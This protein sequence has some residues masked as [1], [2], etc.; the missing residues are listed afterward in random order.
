MATKKA[1]LPKDEQLENQTLDLFEVLAALDRKDYD[2]YDR[3]SEEQQKKFAPFILVHWMS[4]IKGSAGLSAYY[5]MNTDYTANR[6]LLNE[7]VSKHPKLQWLMLCAA[8]PGMGKQ[9][10]QWIPSISG[11]VAKLQ[12]PAKLK[13]IKDYYKNIYPKADSGDIDA[14]SQAYVD[15]H[16]RKMYLAEQYPSMKYEDIELLSEV[17]TTEQIKQHEKDRGN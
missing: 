13:D 2:Y 8:S 9:F 10:H 12:E 1:Q 5:L 16:K 3:L 4:A 11:K 17:V 14:V 6:Y 15:T 7:H